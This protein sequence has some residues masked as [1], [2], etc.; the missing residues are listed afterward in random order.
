QDELLS[1]EELDGVAGGT[2]DEYLTLTNILPMGNTPIGR[3]TAK[4]AEEWLKRNLNIDATIYNK[5]DS[6]PNVYKRNGETLDHW[7]VYKECNK[8]LHK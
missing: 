2:R 4:E 1:D 5:S 7:D 3:M 6:T 8:F